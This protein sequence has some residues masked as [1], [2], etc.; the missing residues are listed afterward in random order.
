VNRISP[1]DLGM[2]GAGSHDIDGNRA[3]SPSSHDIADI[4]KAKGSR[5]C[6][7]QVASEGIAW[8]VLRQV[9]WNLS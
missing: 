7:E 5:E 2:S 9:L 3:T 8:D 6:S 4:G 1:L